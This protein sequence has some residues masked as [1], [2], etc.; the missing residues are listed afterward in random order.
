[1]YTTKKYECEAWASH[2]RENL[3][4]SIQW[5]EYTTWCDIGGL[6]NAFN[7]PPP[8]RCGERKG[9]VYLNELQ[10]DW[11]KTTQS[12][13]TNFMTDFENYCLSRWDSRQGIPQGPTRHLNEAWA[14][15]MGKYIEDSDTNWSVYVEWVE[16]GGGGEWFYSGR[17]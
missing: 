13:D 16:G 6:A 1:M 14:I 5:D 15:H 17:G 4:S 11:E 2:V 12:S 3:P 7:H 9:E 8:T 10:I